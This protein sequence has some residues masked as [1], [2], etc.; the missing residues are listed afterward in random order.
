MTTRGATSICRVIVTTR[1]TS[2]TY[3][4]GWGAWGTS[5]RPGARHDRDGTAMNRLL[6]G[7]AVV[8][9][10]AAS[11][12]SEP[13]AVPASG[14]FSAQLANAGSA[15]RDIAVQLLGADAS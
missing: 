15:D 5:R 3:C 11:G 13:P 1:S 12:C 2:A 7:L 6:T 14:T 10:V 8:R 9:A 4:A